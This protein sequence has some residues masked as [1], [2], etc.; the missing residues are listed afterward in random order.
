MHDLYSD[1]HLHASR[2]SIDSCMGIVSGLGS[3]ASATTCSMY[4]STVCLQALLHFAVRQSSQANKLHLYKQHSGVQASDQ[5]LRSLQATVAHQTHVPPSRQSLV[6]VEERN[7][8]PTLQTFSRYL[9]RQLHHGR[10]D[11]RGF[12]MGWA[13]FFFFPEAF[14][15]CRRRH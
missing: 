10:Q 7:R 5:G 11:T 1:Q 14:A 4:H 3:S 2:L 12:I 8:S 9:A 15:R 13:R 6:L